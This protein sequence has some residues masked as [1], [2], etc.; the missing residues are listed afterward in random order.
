MVAVGMP[1]VERYSEGPYL[2]D[3]WHLHEFGLG[4]LRSLTPPGLRMTRVTGV[5]FRWC[6][7]Q[8]V[9]RYEATP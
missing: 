6:P 1:G 2:N 8:W 3:E 4:L 5:P 7:L 9:V